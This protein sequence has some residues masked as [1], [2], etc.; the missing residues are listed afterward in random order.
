MILNNISI[1]TYTILTNAPFAFLIIYSYF[2]L[3]IRIRYR[4]LNVAFPNALDPSNVI[5]RQDHCVAS[6]EVIER[7]SILAHLHDSLTD[8][9]GLINDCF[10]IAV[11]CVSKTIVSIL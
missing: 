8:A 11:S 4:S 3:T 1:V 2:A 9:M 6:D 7:L 5:A 10:S